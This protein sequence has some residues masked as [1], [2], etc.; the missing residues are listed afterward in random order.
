MT[1]RSIRLAA[2]GLALVAVLAVLAGCTSGKSGGPD[3]AQRS[4]GTLRLAVVGLATLDP[5]AV[6]P[7]DQAEMVAA[8][9]MA[10]G[11]TSVDA[12]SGELRPALASAWSADSDGT[13]WTF[14]LRESATFSDGSPVTASTVVDA[15][16]RV[17]RSGSSSLAAARLEGI[18][19]YGDLVAGK[20]STLAGLAAPDDRTVTITTTSP[21]V[22]LPLLLASPVYGVV[23]I[24][25]VDAGAEG[26]TDAT[27]TTSTTTA[28]ARGLSPD[29]LV[30]SGPFAVAS[31]DGTTLHLVRSTGSAAQL[32][33]VDLIRMPDGAAADAAVGRGDAE[34]ASLAGAQAAAAT[35][36]T[37]AAA[38]SES[39]GSTESTGT[40]PG[41]P[42]TV[43]VDGPLGA[44]EFFGLNVANPVLTNPV[45]R[46]AIVKAIDRSTLVGATTPGLRVSA[47]VV[48]PGVPGASADPCGEPCAY[49]PAASKA[50]V[51]QAFP[52]GG[53]TTVEVDT[54]DDPA[55]VALAGKVQSSLAAVGIPANVVVKPFA[56]YQKFVTSGQQQLFR[57]GWVGLA[58]SP[59]AYLDPLFRSNSL[60]NLTALA[61]PDIDARLR[62]AMGTADDAERQK[63]YASIETDVMGQSPVVPLGSF[64]VHVRLSSGVQDYF[65]RLDGTFDAER[66]RVSAG[67]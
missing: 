46:K 59:G 3:E 47:A 61:S 24:R 8:D 51:A 27:G 29:Q 5:A 9:L 20:T 11:L 38:T 33:G 23:K 66:V 63:Q 28:A 21:N 18:A 32:N 15:L 40:A 31:D 50:L 35:T 43:V 30:G 57:T 34:W 1:F 48:P 7:T 12:E 4:G 26:A 64:V 52:N 25:S 65:P 36:T 16:T 67:G 44:E 2:A 22:E 13:T 42:G 49:D 54:D 45:F 14:T 10:D 17:A 55:N 58:P 41:Q 37:T 60:D 53:V 62:T 6:V 56:E 39:T 19:G